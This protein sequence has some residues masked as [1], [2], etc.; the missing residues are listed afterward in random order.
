[1]GKCHTFQNLLKMWLLLTC[2]LVLLFPSIVALP[3]HRPRVVVRT[4]VRT[5]MGLSAS[6]AWRQNQ[7][8]LKLI[9]DLKEAVQ[10][11][12][13]S[14][15][16]NRTTAKSVCKAVFGFFHGSSEH[17]EIDKGCTILADEFS[18]MMKSHPIHK[19]AEEF[20]KEALVMIAELEAEDE[21]Q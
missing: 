16:Y 13:D 6:D 4:T 14:E 7:K 19:K 18:T 21:A 9:A 2:F 3:V 15:V 11:V 5:Q 12:N 20:K 1:V 8:R 17:E 10:D